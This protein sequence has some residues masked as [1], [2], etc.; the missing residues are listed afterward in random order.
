[1]KG[2]VKYIRESCIE[3]TLLLLESL[4]TNDILKE[5]TLEEV[6]MSEM[7][8]IFY[9][10]YF[11]LNDLG[12]MPAP[13]YIGG[14]KLSKHYKMTFRNIP[15]AVFG[16]LSFNDLRNNSRNVSSLI[17]FYDKYEEGDDE[18]EDGTLFGLLLKWGILL[19]DS[20]YN[21]TS[22]Q[23]LYTNL[24]TFKN[25]NNV[26]KMLS[27]MESSENYDLLDSFFKKSDADSVLKSFVGDIVKKTFY[28]SY[29]HISKIAKQQL[30]L[31]VTSVLKAFTTKFKEMVMQNKIEAIMAVGKDARTAKMYEKVLGMKQVNQSDVSDFENNIDEFP[32]ALSDWIDEELFENFVYMSTHSYMATH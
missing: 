21:I 3:Q 14:Y 20:V 23:K 16:I 26:L 15:I 18:D 13:E 10:E 1:M 28:V 29:L 2:L 32:S 22:R 11:D 25:S 8:N 4:G 5:M 30:D 12:G 9:G 19:Y 17:E 24:K 7:D 27:N 31:G 6:S